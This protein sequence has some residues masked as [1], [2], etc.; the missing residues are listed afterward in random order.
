[1]TP[2][3]RHFLI[4]V[5][6]ASALAACAAPRGAEDEEEL[7][8]GE[9]VAREAGGATEDADTSETVLY[10]SSTKEAELETGADAEQPAQ[11]DEAAEDEDEEAPEPVVLV[12]S[13]DGAYRIDDR[14]V[15]EIPALIES[16]EQIRQARK[17]EMVL[18]EAPSEVDR[19]VLIDA[20]TAARRAGFSRIELRLEGAPEVEKPP[21]ADTPEASPT[22]EDSTPADDDASEK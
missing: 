1:M 13:K 6:F 10:A 8:S 12:V 20:V 11:A 3:V 22:D 21:A 18:I 4:L 5:C 19:D 15:E 9:E 16:L 7:P 2:L 17:T 14:A